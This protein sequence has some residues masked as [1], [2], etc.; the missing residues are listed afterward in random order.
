MISLKEALNLTISNELRDEIKEREAI[1]ETMKDPTH[2][3]HMKAEMDAISS[4]LREVRKAE[5]ERKGLRKDFLDSIGFRVIKDDG[6]YGEAHFKR[7][8]MTHIK[9]NREGHSCTYFGKS[10]KPNISVTVYK[11]GGT[12]TAFNG[13][14][15]TD[16]D[17]I[18]IL[19]KTW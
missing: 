15:Y 13:Y 11:D 5:M 12:R 17:L 6:Q 4:K 2:A 8:E 3:A 16:E 14:I 9:W 18:G 10:L 1:L 19:E 7:S